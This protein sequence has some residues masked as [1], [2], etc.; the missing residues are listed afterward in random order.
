M[1]GID[2]SASITRKQFEEL[3]ESTFQELVKNIRRFL[4]DADMKP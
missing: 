1:D 2:F 4:F 3:A